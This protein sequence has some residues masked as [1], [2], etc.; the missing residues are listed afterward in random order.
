MGFY[1]VDYEEARG[2]IASNRDCGGREF[3]K[4]VLMIIKEA[5]GR[6]TFGGSIGGE[7]RN[8]GGY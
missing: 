4:V 2:G 8:S 1:R 7:A 6:L 3:V 5:S